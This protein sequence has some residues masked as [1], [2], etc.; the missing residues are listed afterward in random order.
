[1]YEIL[2][3]DGSQRLGMELN[4]YRSLQYSIWN[5]LK[6]QFTTNISQLHILFL[7]LRWW[8]CSVFYVRSLELVAAVYPSLSKTCLVKKLWIMWKYNFKCLCVNNLCIVNVIHGWHSLIHRR[9]RIST[10][11]L[12]LHFT[13]E[14]PPHIAL[15]I[16]GYWD[17]RFSNITLPMYF[18]VNLRN[19]WLLSLCPAFTYL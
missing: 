7:H 4:R 10:L 11:L 9:I 3:E 12:W 18:I 16:Q 6:Y 13:S 15:N 2:P 5:R 19:V 8:L 14:K 1:M 17:F